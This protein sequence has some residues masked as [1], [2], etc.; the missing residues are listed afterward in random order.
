LLEPTA[1][2]SATA[3]RFAN[4]IP[5]IWSMS[6]VIQKDTSGRAD[7]ERKAKA[8]AA[9]EAAGKERRRQEIEELRKQGKW[10]RT[11]T[12]SASSAQL[13]RLTAGASRA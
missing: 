3:L 6:C 9:A 5:R 11:R 2:L 7:S 13:K 12:S 4:L 1:R 10:K 8:A